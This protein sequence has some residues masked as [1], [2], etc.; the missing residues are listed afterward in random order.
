MFCVAFRV[1][2]WRRNSDNFWR[3]CSPRQSPAPEE[4]LGAGGDCCAC[5]LGSVVRC[6]GRWRH[7][8]RPCGCDRCGRPFA[9]VRVRLIPLFLGPGWCPLVTRRNGTLSGVTDALALPPSLS[10]GASP[11]RHVRR[12]GSRLSRIAAW[13][14]PGREP[15]L[16]PALRRAVLVDERAEPHARLAERPHRRVRRAAL[17]PFS[18]R[19]QQRLARRPLR[20]ATLALPRFQ[21]ERD[22]L[23]AMQD[24]GVRQAGFDAAL[25]A[26]RRS[27]PRTRQ[28]RSPSQMCRCGRAICRAGKTTSLALTPPHRLMYCASMRS[29]CAS[30]A[31]PIAA[32]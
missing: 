2:R 18:A 6:L 15:G 7:H 17:P 19:P 28:D 5:W 27:S 1:A 20:R 30:T 23:P 8:D 9:A 21:L 32:A 12:V 22:E 14:L 31:C 11:R 3:R 26:W 24:Q 25:L 10:C 29:I 13:H 16:S 4:T